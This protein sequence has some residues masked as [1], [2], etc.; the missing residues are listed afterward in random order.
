MTRMNKAELNDLVEKLIRIRDRY[1]MDRA[2]RDSLAD[3]CNVIY[4]NID[5]MTGDN[6][7]GKD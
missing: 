7:N 1:K 3:A 5:K 2:D 6:E 4:Y